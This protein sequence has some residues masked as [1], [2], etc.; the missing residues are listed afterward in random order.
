MTSFRVGC[1][2]EIVGYSAIALWRTL[3]VTP[4]TIHQQSSEVT[5]PD[6]NVITCFT[7]EEYIVEFK[8]GKFR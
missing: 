4:F 3:P 7:C 5:E 8:S 1:L 2:S 6:M